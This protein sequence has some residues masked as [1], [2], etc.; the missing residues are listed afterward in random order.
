LGGH[1]PSLLKSTNVDAATREARTAL[2]GALTDLMAPN[3]QTPNPAPT[4]AIRPM[5]RQ[6]SNLD[7]PLRRLAEAEVERPDL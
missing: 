6:E 5:P 4:Q 1:E 7:L 2:R 3:N